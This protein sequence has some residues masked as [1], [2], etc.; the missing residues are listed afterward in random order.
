MQDLTIL[1]DSFGGFKKISRL[2]LYRL[3][4]QSLLESFGELSS[5]KVLDLN[6]CSNLTMLPYSFG[7]LTKMQELKLCYSE[8]QILPII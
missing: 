6:L 1:P 4:I 2:K 5:L 7:G 8:L 3:G